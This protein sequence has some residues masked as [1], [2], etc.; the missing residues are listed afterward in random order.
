MYNPLDI[1]ESELLRRLKENDTLAFQELYNRY[2]TMLYL[3][4]YDKLKN[5]EVAKDLV[6]DLFT[7]IWQKRNSLTINGKIIRNYS[8]TQSPIKNHRINRNS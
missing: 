1:D 5:R 4:A 3:H 8:Y 2:Y 7:N 6:H